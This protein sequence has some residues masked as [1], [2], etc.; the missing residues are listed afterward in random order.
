MLIF[1][2]IIYGEW[3]A[4]T[5]EEGC[6]FQTTYFYLKFLKA[7]EDNEI[8][9]KSFSLHATFPVSINKSRSNSTT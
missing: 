2:L 4:F 1:L 8:S 6:D 7:C 5:W 9:S 3:L